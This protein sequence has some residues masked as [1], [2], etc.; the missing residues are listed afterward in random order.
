VTSASMLAAGQ[1]IA[2]L[3]SA[4]TTEEINR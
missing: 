2:F 3:N 1:S 4:H